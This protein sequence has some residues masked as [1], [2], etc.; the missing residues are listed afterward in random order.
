MTCKFV[1]EFLRFEQLLLYRVL[2]RAGA[3]PDVLWSGQTLLERACFDVSTAWVKLLLRHGA[4]PNLTTQ[5]MAPIRAVIH[6]NHDQTPRL[7]QF[8]FLVV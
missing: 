8:V 5:W 7:I 4:N 6:R 2:L 3:S 1:T